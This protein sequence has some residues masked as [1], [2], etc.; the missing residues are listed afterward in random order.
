MTV[1]W[2]ARLLP[3]QNLQ[4]VEEVC[5]TGWPGPCQLYQAWSLRWKFFGPLECWRIRPVLRE[6]H[7]WFLFPLRQNRR[8]RNQIWC[9]W[10]EAF[11]ETKPAM[12]AKV[13]SKVKSRGS[14]EFFIV[15]PL[16]L[17][18]AF[19]RVMEV[20]LLVAFCS[21]CWR[22]NACHLKKDSVSQC[23]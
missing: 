5:E 12:R 23:W 11:V 20:P 2:S 1:P 9:C 4:F 17:A 16:A 10:V 15:K 19:Q 22:T 21:V 7:A 8:L 18:L 13:G 3:D 14:Q 6:F